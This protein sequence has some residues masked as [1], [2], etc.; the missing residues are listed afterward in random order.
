[1]GLTCSR[2]FGVSALSCRNFLTGLVWISF[3]ESAKDSPERTRIILFFNGAGR[4]KVSMLAKE[5]VAPTRSIVD[6]A[7]AIAA[8]FRNFVH[9]FL[10]LAAWEWLHITS[11]NNRNDKINIFDI[12]PMRP[13]PNQ[14]IIS[15]PQNL[16][17][18]MHAENNILEEGYNYVLFF[19]QSY[20]WYLI[21]LGIFF[22]FA[23]PFINEKLKQYSLEQANNPYRRSILD[24]DRKK[25]RMA[26]QRALN[27]RHS[28]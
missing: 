19:I 18:I 1:M 15:G 5:C 12:D 24:E 4:G 22:Y 27:E 13:I 21:G 25:V 23:R 8:C 26:Q 17:S 10:K 16:L 14:K 6:D 3:L 11:T 9:S 2:P 20:G 28:D 7:K